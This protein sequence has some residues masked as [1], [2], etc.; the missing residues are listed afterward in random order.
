MKNVCIPGAGFVFR[1]D[2]LS[3]EDMAAKLHEHG[4]FTSV[5]TGH[6]L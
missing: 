1:P 4:Y 5:P 3:L 6:D 2:G